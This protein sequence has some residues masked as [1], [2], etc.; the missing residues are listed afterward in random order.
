MFNCSTKWTFTGNKINSIIISSL[1][2]MAPNFCGAQFSWIGRLKHFAK[3]IFADGIDASNKTA[4]WLYTRLG[5][6]CW[7]CPKMTNKTFRFDLVMCDCTLRDVRVHP[8][9]KL[10]LLP[11]CFSVGLFHLARMPLPWDHDLTLH[12]KWKTVATVLCFT[13]PFMI[14]AYCSSVNLAYNSLLSLL[15]QTGC[16]PLLCKIQITSMLALAMLYPL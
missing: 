15:R 16:C 3:I 4:E 2:R 8:L 9:S 11:S 6:S 12:G 14:S 10:A 1:Y 13:S 7:E 5:E